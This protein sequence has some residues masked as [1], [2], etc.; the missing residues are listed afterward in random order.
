MPPHR[1]DAKGY[2]LET[3]VQVIRGAGLLI[4]ALAEPA[5]PDAAL[6]R[7]PAAGRWHRLPAFLFVRAVKGRDVVPGSM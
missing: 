2:P 5:I 1:T 4:D 3:Y 7:D 6:A